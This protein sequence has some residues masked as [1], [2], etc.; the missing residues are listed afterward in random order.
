MDPAALPPGHAARIRGWLRAAGVDESYYA[1][2]AR[3]VDADD[4]T[5]RWCCN[6]NCDPCVNTLARVVDQARRELA[7]PGGDAHDRQ[8]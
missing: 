3:H 8:G 2:V 1:F 4:A 7:L 5:W 6:S